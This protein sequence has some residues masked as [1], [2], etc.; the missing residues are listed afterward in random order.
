MQLEQTGPGQY[1]RKNTPRRV[2]IS[3]DFI[4]EMSRGAPNNYRRVLKQVQMWQR[5]LG[6]EEAFD[7]A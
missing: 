3:D 1:V 5:R 4:D 7:D 6:Y 2:V